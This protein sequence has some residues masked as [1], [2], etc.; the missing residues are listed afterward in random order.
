[1]KPSDGKGAL[2]F[3]TQSP[4][5]R[6]K[7]QE[8]ELGAPAAQRMCRNLPAPLIG[9]VPVVSNLLLDLMNYLKSESWIVMEITHLMR[10]T[11]RLYSK[12]QMFRSDPWHTQAEREGSNSPFRN[13]DNEAALNL[14]GIIQSIQTHV[15]GQRRILMSPQTIPRGNAAQLSLGW[16]G[17]LTYV[18]L[19]QVNSR[20]LKPW[21]GLSRPCETMPVENPPCVGSE[22][23]GDQ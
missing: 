21:N 20:R 1:M 16:N 8:T 13:N 2:T 9:A 15:C 12:C 6:A 10:D 14:G 5:D 4:I 11:N 3:V 7:C 22:H 23:R 17:R 19:S 18:Q